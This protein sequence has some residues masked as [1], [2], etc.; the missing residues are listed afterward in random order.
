MP[1]PNPAP[2]H[3][4]HARLF[5]IKKDT[6]DPIITPPPEKKWYFIYPI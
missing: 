2:S 6:A 4:G 5:K 1:I 3:T